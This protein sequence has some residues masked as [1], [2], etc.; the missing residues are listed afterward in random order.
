MVVIEWGAELGLCFF[1]LLVFPEDNDEVDVVFV[2]S[3]AL[4]LNVTVTM[5]KTMTSWDL[6]NDCLPLVIGTLGRKKKN[7]GEN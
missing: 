3:E 5:V 4:R 1:A 2:L 7:E 6:Q